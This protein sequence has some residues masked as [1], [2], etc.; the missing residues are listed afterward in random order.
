ML[1]ALDM[2]WP[3]G[4]LMGAVCLV[5]AH[6]SKSVKHDANHMEGAYKWAMG[7]GLLLLASA[8]VMWALRVQPYWHWLRNSN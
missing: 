2:F 7:G 4:L 6:A 1:D 8:I 5:A 3:I